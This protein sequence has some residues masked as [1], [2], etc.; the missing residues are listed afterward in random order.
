VVSQRRK[1]EKVV[2]KGC[3]AGEVKKFSVVSF[4]FS[5]REEK[6]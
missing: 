6:F 5:V 4:Q 1:I 3:D 2:G